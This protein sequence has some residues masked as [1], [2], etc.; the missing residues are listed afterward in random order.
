[1]STQ[2][3][4]QTGSVQEQFEQANTS[5]EAMI[6]T[7]TQLRERIARQEQ[8]ISEMAA[9]IEYAAVLADDVNSPLNGLIDQMMSSIEQFVESDLPFELQARRDQVERI[10]NL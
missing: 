2:T 7:N 6:L 1:M 4:A 10:R 8:L 3:F 9:N 5:L